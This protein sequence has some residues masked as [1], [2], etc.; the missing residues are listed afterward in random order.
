MASRLQEQYRKTIVPALQEK[1]GITNVMAV[2]KIEKVVINTGIGRM[3][4]DDKAI[5]KTEQDL[6]I[7]AGQ[8][9]TFRK[10]KKSIASFKVREGMPVGIAVTLRGKRMYDFIDRLINIALP[11]SKDFRGIDTKNVDAQGNLNMGIKEHNIFPE[12]NY[13]NIKDIFGL[14]VTV[15]TDAKERE[16]GMELFRLLGFPFKK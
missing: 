5:E 12:I 14:Q 16:Q 11:M 4:K 3:L 10:A 13:E 2:P 8:K 6:A 1:F 15:T 7:L 9:A